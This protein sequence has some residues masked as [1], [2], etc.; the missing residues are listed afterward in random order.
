MSGK[1]FTSTERNRFN[2]IKDLVMS[3]VKSRDNSKQLNVKRYEAL[4]QMFEANPNEFRNWD[5]LNSD[6]LDST[7]QI[8]ALPFEEPTMPQIK[9]AADILNCPLEEYIYYKM[10]NPRGIRSKTKVPVGYVHIKRVQQLLSKKNHYAMD[11]DERSLKTGDVKGESKVASIS[12]VEAYALSAIGADNALKEFYGP[13]STNEKK[14]QEMYR[15]IARDGYCTLSE[16]D[17]IKSPSVTLQTVNTYLLASGIR[18]D[19][20]TNT[21]KTEYTIDQDLKNVK[22]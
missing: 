20:I 7:I 8:F 15:E 2:R 16:I 18:S 11:N 22:G 17:K 5:V 4:F 9:H 6:D 13:R 14:K 3:V 1:P 21:L 19:L 12:D 10:N